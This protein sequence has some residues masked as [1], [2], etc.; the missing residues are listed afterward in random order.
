MLVGSFVFL[1]F[2]YSHSKTV[3]NSYSQTEYSKYIAQLQRRFG[4]I[5]EN[6]PIVIVDRDELQVQQ[7]ITGKNLNQI[8]EDFL[9]KHSG[10]DF[11]SNDADFIRR[12]YETEARVSIPL[13]YGTPEEVCVVLPS[14]P[15][16]NAHQEAHRLLRWS[17]FKNV[18][19]YQNKKVKHILSKEI[20]SKLSDYHEI[21]HCLDDKYMVELNTGFAYFDEG[22][23]HKSEIFAEV[24]GMLLL[25]QDGHNQVGPIRSLYRLLGSFVGGRYSSLLGPRLDMNEISWGTV[26]S[27]YRSVDVAQEYIDSYGISGSSLQETT[28]MA[29]QITENTALSSVEFHAHSQLQKRPK[30]LFQ[31][32]EE[33]K[34]ASNPLTREYFVRVEKATIQYQKTSSIILGCFVR[35]RNWGQ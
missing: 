28:E 35:G 31:L 30:E 2:S 23:I 21:S 5:K 27:I 13:Y 11:S 20:A 1:T 4:S 25:A 8:V 3:G 15:N 7:S 12:Y 10:L 22:C 14:S 26:Y 19:E 24:H 18:P 17:Y 34:N 16:G 6:R 29:L 9:E 33:L 32:I